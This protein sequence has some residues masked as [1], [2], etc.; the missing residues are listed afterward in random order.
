MLKFI[1]KRILQAIPLLLLI[2]FIVFSLI[3]VAPFDVIDS[4]T[5]P[6]MTPEQ[7]AILRQ[8]HGLDQP[9]L[10]QYFIW[11]KNI[12]TG[13]FGNS[14]ITQHSIA[15]DLAEKI[16]NTVSLVLPAYLTALL[17]AVVLGLL[18]AANRGKWVDKAVDAFASVGI[19][20]PTFWFA[21][22]LIYLFGY[23]LKFF[24][25]IGMHTLGKERDLGDFMAHFILPYLTLIMASM[26]RLLRYIRTSA[27]IEVDK[28]YV[29]VQEAFQSHRKDIFSRHIFRNISI[30]IVTQIGMAL[31]MLVA[32]AVITETIFAWPGVGPYL[33]S[34]TK[35]L[36][37]PVIMSVML[38][39]AILVILGNLLA[40]VLYSIVDPRITRGGAK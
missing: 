20:V 33:T 34:A 28:D 39:S 32:G 36:D 9:F 17:L 10:T 18:A 37:Y 21:M 16:P 1:A 13:N 12:L 22:I 24:P 3:Q 30:P 7:V 8:Q 31:P 15:A 19:A 35:A 38:L 14:M 6:N 2:S 4:L 25:F 5:T 26:P 40:D 27:I 23:R 29:T 11:L